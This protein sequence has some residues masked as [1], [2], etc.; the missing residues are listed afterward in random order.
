MAAEMR[1]VAWRTVRRA[2]DVTSGGL[3]DEE[4]WRNSG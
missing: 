2:V 1:A 3:S 4:D